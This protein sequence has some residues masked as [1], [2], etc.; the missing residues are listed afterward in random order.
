MNTNFFIR[1][2]LDGFGNYNFRYLVVSVTEIVTTDVFVDKKMF[3]KLKLMIF[4]FVTVNG[5]V[6]LEYYTMFELMWNSCRSR[7]FCAVSMI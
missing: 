4:R 6:S 1:L 2:W 7:L 3:L 5:T